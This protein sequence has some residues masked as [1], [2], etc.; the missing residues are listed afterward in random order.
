MTG[1]RVWSERFPLHLY[2]FPSQFPPAMLGSTSPSSQDSSDPRGE[3]PSQ[4]ELN[5]HPLS[6]ATRIVYWRGETERGQA[7]VL[8]THPYLPVPNNFLIACGFGDTLSFAFHS[9]QSIQCRKESVMS[10]MKDLSPMLETV[11]MPTTDIF[12]TTTMSLRNLWKKLSFR[13]AVNQIGRSICSLAD[14]KFAF[15]VIWF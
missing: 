1:Y 4:C 12:G 9:N 11:K 8:R 10:T 13:N 6:G 14:G 15:E 3:A 7:T 5:Q 2:H